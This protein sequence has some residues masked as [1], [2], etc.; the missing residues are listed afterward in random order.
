MKKSLPLIL[1]LALCLALLSGCEDVVIGQTGDA[2]SAPASAN[3]AD[4]SDSREIVLSGSSAD[5]KAGGVAISGSTVTIK[6]G[7]TYSV[8]GK[9]DDGQIIVNT[10]DDPTDVVL[11]LNNADVTCLSGPAIHVQQARNFDLQLPAGTSNRLTSGTEADMALCDDTKSG[12]AIF[13][14]DDLDIKGEGALEINGYINNGITCKDDIDIQGG[15]VSVIAANNG[16][17]GSESV[18]ISDCTLN[19][20]AA[21]DGIKS[22]SAVKAGKGYVTVHS[23]SITILSTGGDGISA[24]TELNI[25]GGTINITTQG[26]SELVSSKGLKG[27]TAVNISGGEITVLST[28]HAVRSASVISVTDGVL[29]LTS[30]EGKAIKADS[31]ITVSGGSLELSAFDD[32]IASATALTISGGDIFLTA[33]NDGLKAGE[34]ASGFNASSGTVLI[35]GGTTVV[36]ACA[37]PIDA[38][39]SATV[40]GG[41][42]LAIGYSKTLKPLSAGQQAAVSQSFGISQ[43]AD[44][45]ALDGSGSAIASIPAAAY[46]ANTVIVSAPSVT[47]GSTVTL[48]SGTDSADFTA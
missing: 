35:S 18:E 32:G 11:I 47:P 24:E 34:K 14:E 27:N 9:L 43:G 46:K 23:G 6:A 40:D 1:V 5:C 8:T 2:S 37:D 22:T 15:T 17:R 10:G 28:D 13:A 12:G 7:G 48:T 29:S 31:D 36:S 21:N 39:L 41:T 38:K 20:T 44:V 45:S 42:V 30:T 19:I 16:V 33:G 4:V 3:T 25:L 26:N